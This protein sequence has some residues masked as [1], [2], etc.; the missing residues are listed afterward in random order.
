MV[1][2]MLFFFLLL[3]RFHFLEHFQVQSKTEQKEQRILLYSVLPIQTVSPTID[4]L[5]Q[6]GTWVTTDKSTLTYHYQPNSIYKKLYSRYYTFYMFLKM[7]NDKY[8]PLDSQRIHR[9][10]IENYFT[11]PKIFPSLLLPPSLLPSSNHRSF[12]CIHSFAFPRMSYSE[13]QTVYG[14]FRLS[15]FTSVFRLLHKISSRSFW[16]N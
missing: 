8:P 10:F 2:L 14:F 3:N 9:L 1:F 4:I 13:S 11:T 16:A 7:C 6:S 12:Y 15:S 5:Y